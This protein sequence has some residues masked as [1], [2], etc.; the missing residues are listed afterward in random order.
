[1]LLSSPDGSGNPFI[2]FFKKI[3]DWNVQQKKVETELQTCAPNLV[4]IL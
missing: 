1:M 3:K 2:F 4:F